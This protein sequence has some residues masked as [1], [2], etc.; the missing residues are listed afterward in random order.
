MVQVKLHYFNA[1]GR[2]E[3]IRWILEYAGVKYEDIR[4]EREQWPAAKK[5]MLTGMVPQL[6]YD[7]FTL[8]ETNAIQHFLGKTH[9]L[10][11]KDSKE[12]AMCQMVANLIGDYISKVGKMRFETDEEK[13]K[14][15][16]VELKETHAPQFFGTMVKLL[17]TNDGKHLVG[18]TTTYADII[19]ACLLDNTMRAAPEAE[20]KFPGVIL[21]FKKSI[22]EVPNLKDWINKRPE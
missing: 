4:Y 7:G 11:G 10:A 6:E 1:K 8:A 20:K 5:E 12:E 22:V 3:A 17:K 2:A 19:L 15:L 14:K 13:K 16:E 9:N 21:E 18:S